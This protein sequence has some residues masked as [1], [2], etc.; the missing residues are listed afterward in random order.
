MQAVDR[1]PQPEKKKPFWL[2]GNFA[3]VSEEVTA[4]ELK[5]TGSLPPELQG[6]FLRNGPNPKSGESSHWFFGDGMIHGV[7][8]RDGRAL[9]YRNRWIRTRTFTDGVDPIH[10][11]GT[12]DITT[13]VANT[14]VMAHAGKIFALVESSLPTE[15]TC[16]LETVG[17]Y[18]FGGRLRTAMTAHPKVCPVTGELHFFGYDWLQPWLVYHRADAAGNLVQSEVIEV[19]APTMIHDFA[20]TDRHVVF[21]DLPIVFDLERAM[22]GTMPYRWSDDYG[23]RV[24][25]MPR[26]GSNADVRWFEVEPCYVFHPFNAFGNGET[27]TVDVARYPQL[28]R[29]T[30][31]AFD[32]ARAHRW[33]FDLRSGSVKERALD[34]RSIEFP[35][36]DERLTGLEHRYAYAAQ[37]GSTIARCGR[38][39]GMGARLRLRRRTQH[40]RSRR[41]RRAR[42]RGRAASRGRVTAARADGLSRQLGPGELAPA[43]VTRA[44][45]S[46]RPRA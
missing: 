43:H 30:P 1:V 19:P 32:S 5:V 12:R 39:R 20:I 23:A 3:P 45:A 40:E 46:E 2:R 36:V 33:T 9:W 13:G 22:Q 4:H 27:V 15:I 29:D 14:H 34:D 25:I 6:T 17:P 24:G 26:G 7:A 11:D 41:A 18:D 21:M 31:G 35:R 10:P 28:W 38:R 44:G 16:E 8:L 42:L 37:S